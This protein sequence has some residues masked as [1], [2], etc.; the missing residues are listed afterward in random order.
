MPNDV[1]F[2]YGDTEKTFSFTA[3][4]DE[5]EDNGEYVKLAFGIL[6]T[7]VNP[8]TNDETT[9]SITDSETSRLSRKRGPKRPSAGPEYA[10]PESGPVE[11]TVTLNNDPG[12]TDHTHHQDQRGRGQRR[13][14]LQGARRCDLR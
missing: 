2:N 3:T 9:V 1:T 12:Q 4:D 7:G 13:R 6:P 14:L 8:G 11:V 10:V 5:D